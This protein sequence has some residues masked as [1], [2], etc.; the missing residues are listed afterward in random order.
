MTN[1]D[2][3]R[4]GSHMELDKEEL[5]N[6]IKGL[7][8]IPSLTDKEERLIECISQWCKAHELPTQRC[9]N[10]KLAKV[11]PL[12][13]GD[14]DAKYVFVTHCDRTVENKKL[15]EPGNEEIQG[16]LDNTAS[17]AL[18]LILF[19]RYLHK[20]LDIAL[21]IT[22]AEERADN[23]KGG[24]G[25]IDYLDFA[26]NNYAQDFESFMDKKRFIC[27]DVRP[28][29]KNGVL[30]A[31]RSPMNLGDGIVLR[32]KEARENR[33]ILEADPSLI[34]IIRQCANA[35]RETLVDFGGEVIPKG[36][37][38]LGRG[39]EKY[40]EK[41]RLSP[42]K[43]HIAW[44]QPPIRNCETENERMSFRDLSSLWNILEY[45]VLHWKSRAKSVRI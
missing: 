20:A 1:R 7:N 41:E 13:I 18:C 44:I 16:K 10:R 14:P 4:K 6:F 32:L 38:E 24:R 25:F 21:L 22:T 43:Y 29:D 34:A 8:S 30:K 17:L 28:L 5:K 45:F 12:Y 27:I 36:I 11:A 42:C 39:W 40:L 37:T 15:T 33:V 23:Q 2:N 26:K 35:T 9:G 3:P 19:R 31:D